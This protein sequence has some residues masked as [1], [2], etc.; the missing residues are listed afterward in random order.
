MAVVQQLARDG[1]LG[2]RIE[3][4]QI[5][6]AAGRYASLWAPRGQQERAGCDVSAATSR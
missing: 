4:Y 5:G 1:K 3:E 6:V 2:V